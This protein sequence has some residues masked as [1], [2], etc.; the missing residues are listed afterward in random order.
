LERERAGYVP[1]DDAFDDGHHQHSNLEH[2][3]GAGGTGQCSIVILVADNSFFKGVIG[4]DKDVDPDEQDYAH[5]MQMQ[6]SH[7]IIN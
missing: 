1:E 5:G 7:C 6:T 3:S 2:I 4:I